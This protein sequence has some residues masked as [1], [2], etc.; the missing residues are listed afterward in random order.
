MVSDEERD[1]PQVFVAVLI[2]L[3]Q[4]HYPAVAERVGYK[5]MNAFAARTAVILMRCTKCNCLALPTIVEPNLPNICS[6]HGSVSLGYEG[7][8]YS[9]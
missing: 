7:A 9:G 3:E 1:K 5:T 2:R 6:R 8:T 4:G